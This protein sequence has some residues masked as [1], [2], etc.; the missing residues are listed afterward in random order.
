MKYTR[1]NII[2][3]VFKNHSSTYKVIEA[4]DNK[5]KVTLL[6]IYSGNEVCNYS[7]EE[8]VRNFNTSEYWVP[9]VPSVKPLYDIF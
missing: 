7:I 6:N 5:Y 2:G 4:T 1:D 8:V 3:V 9:I